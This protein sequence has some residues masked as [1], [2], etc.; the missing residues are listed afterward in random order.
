MKRR[1]LLQHLHGLGCSLLREGS[2]H[3]I[4]VNRGKNL[5]TA[6]PKHPEIVPS[7]CRKIWRDL[8]VPVPS[9]K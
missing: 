5:T 6:I 7:L 1:K 9:E 4:Y 8:D 3:T 2:R